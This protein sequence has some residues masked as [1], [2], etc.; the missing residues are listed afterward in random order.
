MSAWGFVN[1]GNGGGMDVLDEIAAWLDGLD[2]A[3]LWALLLEAAV[4]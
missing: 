2:A 3:A 4:P 1:R